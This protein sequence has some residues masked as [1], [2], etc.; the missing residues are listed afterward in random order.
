MRTHSR[1]PKC[2]GTKIYVCDNAQS[3][4]DN[5]NYSHPFSITVVLRGT[6]ETGGSRGSAFR[7]EVG[8]YETWI[9]AGCGYT[10]WY[11]KDPEH[12]LEKLSKTPATGVR[13][14]DSTA[15]GPYRG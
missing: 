8:Q 3:D 15:N 6:D 1:C 10:E 13:V 7:T 4:C 11:A 14:V 5:R 12:L 9:C 2:T